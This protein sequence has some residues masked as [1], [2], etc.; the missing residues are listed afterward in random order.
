MRQIP[1]LAYP[2]IGAVLGYH[3]QAL[4]AAGFH[5]AKNAKARGSTPAP[6]LHSK[7]LVGSGST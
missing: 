4:A 5:I 2:L 1:A 7:R 6:L 3:L